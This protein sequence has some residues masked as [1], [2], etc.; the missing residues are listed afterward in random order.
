MCRGDLGLPDSAGDVL[1]DTGRSGG[2]IDLVSTVSGSAYP[3]ASHGVLFRLGTFVSLVR[4]DGVFSWDELHEVDERLVAPSVVEDAA[5]MTL[6]TIS[7][8]SMFISASRF[9][10]EDEFN[11]DVTSILPASWMSGNK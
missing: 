9:P 10:N 7:C 6:F 5:L 11:N 3:L 1:L 8:A 4:R 2:W